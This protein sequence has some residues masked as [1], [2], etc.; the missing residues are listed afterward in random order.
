MITLQPNLQRP[1]YIKH[2]LER[3]RY[4]K[5]AVAMRREAADLIEK[6]NE[7]SS[8]LSAQNSYQAMRIEELQRDL[9]AAQ[10]ALASEREAGEWQRGSR[11]QQITRLE[12]EL[13]AAQTTISALTIQR[14][15]YSKIIKM[16]E[17]ELAA[18]QEWKDRVI[19]ELIVAH[20]YTK[21]HDA[22]PCKA[23]QDAI[24][25]NCQVALDP[26]VSSDARALIA[27]EL[28]A[29]AAAQ[30]ALK[31]AE[32]HEAE[33]HR[34]LGAILG[35]DDSLAQCAKRLCERARR[36]EERAERNA[37]DAAALRRYSAFIIRY[38]DADREDELLVGDGAEEAA[39]KRWE[40]ISV[41]W[42]A[43]LFRKIRGNA[44]ATDW[45][46]KPDSAIARE[47]K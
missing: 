21:E 20:I 34:T 1:F 6:M 5:A 10:E 12:K 46:A 14:D 37:R 16:R 44:D 27:N 29:V 26:A 13:A 35:N 25:W 4:G 38:D 24:T 43:H 18:A 7:D 3:L 8:N 30:E 23:I 31:A 11:D 22:N 42:N 40:Q 45:H 41:N 32:A 47:E 36:A 33:T 15:G 17:E 28:R 39:M 2:L 19:D 9:A